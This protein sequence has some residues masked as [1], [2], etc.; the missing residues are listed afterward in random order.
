MKYFALIGAAGYIAPRHMHAIK[1]TGNEL[2]AAMDPNDSVGIIDSHF[3]N[4][5]FFTEFERF[6]R[7]VDK[8]RRANHSKS[9]HYVSICSPNYLHD[10]HMRFALRSGADA[11]CEKPLVL[12]PWNIDALQV[13]ERDTGHK[14]N[15]ILQLRVHPSIVALREKVQSQPRDTKH[16]VDLTYITS[17]GHWYLRSWKGDLKKSGGIATNIGVHFFD[18]L[19]FIFGELQENVVHHSSDTKAAGYL[20]YEHARARWFL[21]VDVNDVPTAQRAAGQRTYRSI[22]VDGEEIEFSGGFTDLHDRS[23]E[24][25]LAGRG[26]GLE[27]NRNAINTVSTIRNASLAPLSGDYHPFL[28]K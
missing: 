8:M 10:S 18:M 7:H 28:K 15:T 13:L 16:E 3:P 26:Y 2:V 17:R 22:T 6:D 9:I 1:A 11:I 25:I 12:N 23:Y 4:A 20:E 21:S 19:H 27:D 14:V 5:D 24:E